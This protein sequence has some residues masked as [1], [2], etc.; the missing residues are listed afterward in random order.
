M[1]QWPKGFGLRVVGKRG[2]I[3]LPSTIRQV[4]DLKEGDYVLVR[5]IN[6]VMTLTKFHGPTPEIISD[7]GE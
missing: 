3:T 1:S 2:Q 7:D 5:V 6:G 4:M